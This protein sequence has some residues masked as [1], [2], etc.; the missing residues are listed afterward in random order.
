M[1]F[2]RRIK[3]GIT[4]PKARIVVQFSKNSFALGENVEGD[5]AVSSDEVF[6]AKEI[7]CEIQSV[8]EAKRVKLVYDETARREVQKEIL[9]L[10][11]LYS[12]RPTVTGPLHLTK[13]FSQTYPFSIC[14]PAGL[15]PTFKSLDSKITWIFKAAIAIE[16]RPDVTSQTVEIQAIQPTAAQVREKEIIREVVMIPCRY[17]GALMPQTDTTCPRCNAK[18]MAY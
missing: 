15:R 16:G 2:L 17:C 8:E 7:R 6:D 10:A 9:E 13:G 18:R 1:S 3:E 11:T 4:Q 12:A 5:L 14:L